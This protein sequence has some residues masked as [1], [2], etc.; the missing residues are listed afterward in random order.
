MLG[1]AWESVEE[2]SGEC[3]E[4]EEALREVWEEMSGE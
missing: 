1:K 4:C 2:M 3:G